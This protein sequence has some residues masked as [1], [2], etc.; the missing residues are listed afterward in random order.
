MKNTIKRQF[1]LAGEV[2]RKGRRIVKNCEWKNENGAAFRFGR[3]RH[4]VRLRLLLL[5]WLSR[6]RRRRRRVG[7]RLDEGHVRHLP[8][9]AAGGVVNADACMVDELA[10]GAVKLNPRL[11]ISNHGINQSRL[12]AGQLALV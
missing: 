10:G 5:W 11:F 12:R 6:W 7:A 4:A 1:I 2:S 8:D 9:L 3:R